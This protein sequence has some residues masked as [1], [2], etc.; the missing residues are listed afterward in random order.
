M[1]HKVPTKV[2]CYLFDIDGT[3]ADLHHRLHFIR[4]EGQKKD[5]RSF[6][7]ATKDDKPIPH[8]I[9][10]AHKLWATTQIVFVS[11]RSD[12]CR[13]DTEAW[14]EQQG[15]GYVGERS[16]RHLYMRK[17]GD[18]RADDIVKGELLDRILADGYEPIMAFDDRKRV[19]DMWRARGIPCAQVAE[20]DF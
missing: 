12:E 2:R 5:W 6:F 15:F 3:I 1:K 13:E 16:V 14:L 17:A 10:L 8:I 20:G 18:Y 9:E 7:A 4:T 11:G 19:V